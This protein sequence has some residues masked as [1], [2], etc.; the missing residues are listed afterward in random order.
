MRKIITFSL[1]WLTVY[2]F[3][4]YADNFMDGDFTGNPAWSGNTD[5]FVVNGSKQ[6]QLSAPEVTSMA[7]LSTPSKAIDSASWQFYM[8][9]GLLLTSGNYVNFYLVSNS[10][11]LSGGLNG[12]YVMVG[13]TNKE[14]ALYRQSGT[15]KTRLVAGISKR[16]PIAGSATELNVKVTR[17]ASGTWSLYSKLSSEFDFELEGTVTDTT[18]NKSTYSGILCNYSS[19]NS[20]NYIFDD[21]IVTGSAIID[22]VPPAIVSHGLIGN[23]KLV[24]TFSEPINLSGAS[25]SVPAELG[26]FTRKVS[27]NTLEFSFDSSFPNHQAFVVTLDGVA[28]LEG[29]HLPKSNLSFVYHPTAFG[30]LIFNEIMCDP[31]PTVGLPDEE[32]VELYNRQDFPIELSGWTLYYGSKPY[33][34]S[35]GKIPA[36]GYLLLCA[37]GAMITLSGFGSV[38]TMLRF[39]PLSSTGQLLYL[40]NEKDSLIAFVNYSSDWYK[41]KSKASGGWSLECIDNDNFSGSDLNWIASCDVS[42]GTPGRKNASVAIVNDVVIPHISVVSLAAPDT[43]LLQFNKS[44]ILNDLSDMSHYRVEGLSDIRL[45]SMDFPQGRWVKLVLS[46]VPRHGILYRMNASELRDVNGDWLNEVISFG[47]SD[48]C[49]YNDVVLNEILAHPKEEGAP[50]VELYN[51]SQKIIELSSLSLNRI[52]P[53]GD[54]DDACTISSM[55]GQLFPGEYLV[56]TTSQKEVCNFYSCKDDGRWIEMSNFVPLSDASGNV[57]LVNRT[58]AV[59]DSV[60]YDEKQHEVMIQDPAGVSFERVNPDWA[61][62]NPDNWHSCASDAGY[63]TPGYKNSQF[64]QTLERESA[65]KYFWIEN[66]SFTP[67][68]DGVDDALPIRYKMPENGYLA[69]VTIYDAVGRRVRQVANNAV[70]GAEGT[71]AWNGLSDSGKLANIGVYVIYIDAVQP[72]KG[73]RERAK[74]ACVVATK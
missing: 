4:Q 62:D 66:E 39:P 18:F 14:V 38:A 48:S 16:L 57:L 44:M 42:G 73:K 51:R 49:E 35:E 69:T 13:N 47:V 29:N 9:A 34:I 20:A 70:L 32:Y 25:I 23:K 3:G 11:D 10:A 33:A 21:F 28:D 50:F 30:D 17:D 45:A 67:D 5:K 63:A 61:S 31:Y 68:N 40:T 6:L 56:L 65:A 2:S 37:P 12:Y 15:T 27:G 74:I 54:F 52:K 19:S 43:L 55:G 22:T 71:L 8:N 1:L 53:S 58:G 36:K 64:R 41:D 72:I 46:P 24:V 60:S 7:Y 59:I 26:N